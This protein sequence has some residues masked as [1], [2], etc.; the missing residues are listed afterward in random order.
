MSNTLSSDKAHLSEDQPSEAAPQPKTRQWLDD[1]RRRLGKPIVLIGLMGAGKSTVGRRVAT[2]LDCPFTDADEA[3]E[4]A[5]QRSVA[6]IFAAH[7]EAYF[8]EGERRVIARLMEQ[9]NG[10]IAT[11]GGAFCDAETRELILEHGI[12]V[13]L[14]CDVATLVERTNRRNTRPL[15]K[16]GDPHAIL[17]KL[18]DERAPL[19]GLAPI[20]VSGANRPHLE[21]AH[22]ILEA[23]DTW[24]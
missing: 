13:W 20:R 9:K 4:E 6:E 2:L 23:I 22:I 12:A 16:D 21:T 7:G 8:R 19:Y 3:I 5:A 15:L 14:D 11:G 1:L 18:H 17:T 24:L 10:V